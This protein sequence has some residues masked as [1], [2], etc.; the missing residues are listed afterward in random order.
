LWW[1]GA[2]EHYD[3]T[4]VLMTVQDEEDVP[5]VGWTVALP[6]QECNIMTGSLCWAGEWTG[7]VQ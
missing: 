6:V 4:L 5:L 1:Q 2:V 7:S 3:V